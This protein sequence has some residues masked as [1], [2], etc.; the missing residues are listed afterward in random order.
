MPRVL[1]PLFFLVVALFPAGAAAQAPS[2]S[3]AALARAVE[4]MRQTPLIDGH[5]DL[6]WQIRGYAGGDIDSLDIT[7]RHDPDSLHTDIPRLEEG[8]LGGQ[9]WSAYVPVEYIEAGGSARFILQQI[10]LI[11]RLP[12]LYPETFEFATTADD[13]VRIHQNGRIATLIGVEGGHA[14]ENSLDVLRGF[15]G[16]GARYMTLTHFLNT[17]WADAATD[18]PEHQ[19]LTDFGEQVVR[20]MNRLG[21][22]VD[23][24]HVSDS[25]M[26][27][28]IRITE[29]PV[30]FSHSSARALADHPRNVPD[31]VLEML[32]ENGGIVMVTFVPGYISEEVLQDEERLPDLRRDLLA[33]FAGD[34]A[35]ARSAWEAL[36]ADPP[37]VATLSQVA[38]HIDHIVEVAGIDHVGIGGDYDG[39]SSVIVGLEDVTTYPALVAELLLRGYS[40]EEVR[41]IIGENVLRVMREAEATAARLRAGT[42]PIVA[43]GPGE[44]E[45]PL[46]WD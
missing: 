24:S 10:D 12:I 43:P 37:A 25:T 38:D 6:P 33:V 34:T 31:F 45:R 22:L 17:D 18:E 5:N 7:V 35:T 23:L 36:L 26:V 29:A 1:S 15:Y 30:I 13:V 8:L 27:D 41:K 16:L 4:I 39:I 21:M 19:G 40:D 42:D 2:D 3:A 11:H 46:G 32:P 9:F 20:E 14:I 28:A 44:P